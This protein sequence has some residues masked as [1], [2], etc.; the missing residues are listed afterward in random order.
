MKTPRRTEPKN[1]HSDDAPTQVLSSLDTHQDGSIDL[2]GVGNDSDMLLD[3]VPNLPLDLVEDC[4]GLDFDFTELLNPQ[5]SEEIVQY[6]PELSSLASHSTPS[7][8]LGQDAQP[9]TLSPSVSIQTMPAYTIRSFNQR[10][11]LKTGTQRIANLI[12]HTLKSYPLMM[13]RDN[14]LPPF[15]HPHLVSSDVEN[16]DMEPLINCINLVHML[17]SRIHG[18]RKLFWKNV[19]IE[20]ENLYANVGRIQDDSQENRGIQLMSS[21]SI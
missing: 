5:A 2:Q 7:I 14:A 21:N 9:I 12:F 19:R 16:E 18:S 10:S 15:I 17:S 11:R 3:A 20:C 6:P 1:Q 13:L 8:T 4:S